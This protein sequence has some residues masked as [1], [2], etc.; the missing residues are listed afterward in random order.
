MNYYTITVDGRPYGGVDL[1]TE[2]E[3][4]TGA[5]GR[6]HQQGARDA[7]LWGTYHRIGGWMNL[8]SELQRILDRGMPQSELVIR[9]EP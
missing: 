2:E 6:T 9:V 8:R 7:L 3:A 4:P 1:N 5:L